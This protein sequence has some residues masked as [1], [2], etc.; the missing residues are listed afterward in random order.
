MEKL[1]K[2][3]YI[4]TKHHLNRMARDLARQTDLSFSK[5]M[6]TIQKSLNMEVWLNDVYEVAIDRG[7]QVTHLSIKRRDRKPCTDWRDFQEIKN[8]LVGEENEGVELFP[9][10][11]RVVDLANQYHLWVLTDPTN[12]FPFGFDEGRVVDDTM[13]LGKSKQRKIRK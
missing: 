5:A 13:E 11:S 4:L 3:E 6:S 7:E 1:Q 9:A 2:G 12:R 8:Q 10:E